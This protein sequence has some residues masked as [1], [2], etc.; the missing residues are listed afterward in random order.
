MVTHKQ[1]SIN[2]L[3]L[4]RRL[5]LFSGPST[6]DS[7]VEWT[8][9]FHPRQY[10]RATGSATKSSDRHTEPDV[11]YNY[12]LNMLLRQVTPLH[13]WAWYSPG[14][15][16]NVSKEV[17]KEVHATRKPTSVWSITWIGGAAKSN[18]NGP[19]TQRRM[20]VARVVR[21]PTFA[22]SITRVGGPPK[23]P[24]QQRVLPKR[25]R[26]PTPWV[27]KFT[28]EGRLLMYIGS[29]PGQPVNWVIQFRPYSGYHLTMHGDNSTTRQR[30]FADKSLFKILIRG[31]AAYS[32][33]VVYVPDILLDMPGELVERSDI[34]AI[35]ADAPDLTMT[36]TDASP[37][38]SAPCTPDITTII[39]YRGPSIIAVTA[40]VELHASADPVELH[41]SADPEASVLLNQLFDY[42]NSHTPD[43][44]E[45]EPFTPIPEAPTSP[46]PNSLDPAYDD[47]IREQKAAV[48]HELQLLLAA[49]EE[50]ARQ[51]HAGR[52]EKDDNEQNPE[53]GSSGLR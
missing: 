23:L 35:L 43:L 49:L 42:T 28:L 37:S 20:I 10:Y 4:E 8:V 19:K 26:Y 34:L 47:F 48:F 52:Q 7:P 46:N 45:V 11:A 17:V 12:L 40:P 14:I 1:L 50:R 25:P 24:V 31:G 9:L 32:P 30:E 22:S 27:Q 13:P 38:P 36:V 16:I 53:G 29:S 5:M 18:D 33:S 2:T 21:R 6:S 39:E 41:A 44:E 51:I 15:F 3:T